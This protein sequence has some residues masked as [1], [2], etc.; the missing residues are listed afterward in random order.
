MAPFSSVASPVRIRSVSELVPCTSIVSK[1]IIPDSS[2][3]EPSLMVVEDIF[4]SSPKR[5]VHFRERPVCPLCCS[6]D[7]R[8]EK[9]APVIGRKRTRG[10]LIPRKKA[11]HSVQK[12]F[13][14]Q[15]SAN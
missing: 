4:A 13:G 12:R 11:S 1:G 2:R 7:Y 6:P 3:T 14:Q 10:L 8:I 15:H 9:A 5:G